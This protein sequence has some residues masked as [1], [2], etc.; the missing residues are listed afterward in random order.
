MSSRPVSRSTART[1]T[2]RPPAAP[3]LPSEPSTPS[4][5]SRSSPTTS[6]PDATSAPRLAAVRTNASVCRASSICASWYPIAPTY[7]SGSSPGARRATDLRDR[8]WCP[9]SAV[10]LREMRDSVSYRATPAPMYGRSHPRRVRGSRNGSGLT[11]CGAIESSSRPRSASASRT[12]PNSRCS[13]YRSP[14]CARRDERLLVPEAQSRFSS[15]PTVR[16]RVAASSAAPAP[17][18][19]PP[20]TR[21]SSGSAS[22][23]SSDSTR[24]LGPIR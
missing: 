15:S 1:P 12:S 20:M 4:A 9:F 2:T 22:I 10:P 24:S 18:T 5:G 6:I 21:T 16:P 19:P 14:P 13:R 7:F 11:R 8:C 3:S 23:C 17:T